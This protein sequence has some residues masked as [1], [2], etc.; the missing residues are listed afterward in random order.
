[1]VVIKM[2][3]DTDVVMAFLVF[4]PVVLFVAWL[5]KQGLHWLDRWDGG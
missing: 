1:M 4:Y 5:G 2:N 3:S